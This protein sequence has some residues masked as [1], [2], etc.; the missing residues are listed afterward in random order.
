MT[1]PAAASRAVSDALKAI[2]AGARP[3][4]LESQYLDF[5]EYKEPAANDRDSLK[6]GAADLA[7][8]AAC[9]ANARGG[10]IVVGVDDDAAGPAAFVG[11]PPS[12]DEDDL[13][14]RI[15][16]LTSPNL[17]V[18]AERRPAGS[19]EILVLLVEP[20]FDLHRV[21]G[22]LRERIS[23]HCEPMTPERE[24]AVR[25]ERRNYDWSAEL[26]NWT[27][28]DVAETAIEE[29]R[30]LLEQAGDD[31]S[32]RRATLSNED[33]LRECGVLDDDGRLLRAGALLFTRQQAAPNPTIQYL[34]KR[35]P[36]GA[37]T[38]PPEVHA[39]PLLL[40]IRECLRDVDA[41]NETTPVTL[42]SGVQQQLETIPRAAVREAVVN[43]VAHRD[44]R[45]PDQTVI[46]HSPSQLV[47]VSPGELVFGVTEDNLLT[48]S[49]KPR[50]RRLA[51]AL[52]VLRLAER[53][54]TGV[55]VMVRTMVRAGHK[56]PGFTSRG[57][58]VRV[59]LSGG[60]PVTR[61]ASLMANLPDDVREDTDAALTIDYLRSHATVRAKDI[62]PVIQKTIDEAA[63]ALR[64][65]S[66]DVY[67]LIEP[68]RE[69]RR[70]R[71]PAYRFRERVRAELG[72][73]LP[74]HRNEQDEVDR[75]I[76]AH[77]REYPTVS[78]QT[79]Q[80]LCQVQVTRA[81]VL[82]RSLADRQIIKKTDDS[83]ERG[84][85]VRYER[86]PHFPSQSRTR[87]A[88]GSN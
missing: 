2:S 16:Q 31:Q 66:D 52:R 46:E 5:K 87:R 10:A 39:L 59:V 58:A 6:A 47:V 71:M 40:T 18:S 43:A 72:S 15:W 69:D 33:L 84:P 12:L 76:I 14:H 74:Y 41:A 62:A 26:T 78:N 37:L 82:L 23:D 4:D 53:A 75:R 28:K 8:A 64:R 49:S 27:M 55:D 42:A 17:V 20:G 57:G 56:P 54:G 79:V 3:G 73:L 61:V 81:S 30:R 68:T 1:T 51:D 88:T 45:L 80:N 63:D 11:L 60:A 44:Y 83:P 38:R 86:G 36:G 19:A 34:R 70:S 77:L 35:T 25:D 13:R 32:R 24:G 22:K 65:L 9:M 48:H 7:E 21:G 67:A 85:S 50:N 29:A